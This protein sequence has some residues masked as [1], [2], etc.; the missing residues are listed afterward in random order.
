MCDGVSLKCSL[1]KP[2]T[3]PFITLIA[4][5]F[6]SVVNHCVVLC[7]KMTLFAAFS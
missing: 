4:S 5:E 3:R 2:L 6:V 7:V 1:L